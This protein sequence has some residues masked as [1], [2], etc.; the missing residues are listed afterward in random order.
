MKIEDQALPMTT[1]EAPDGSPYLSVID[2][3]PLIRV[4]L[5]KYDKDYPRGIF[6]TFDKKALPDLI[7]AL[8]KY[9][10]Y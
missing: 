5:H 3:D 2:A 8:E 4:Q 6:L 10:Q 1:I 9:E 7:R